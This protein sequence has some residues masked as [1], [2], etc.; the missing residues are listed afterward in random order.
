MT[1]GL[2]LFLGCV[3]ISLTGVWAMLYQ[4]KKKFPVEPISRQ[5]DTNILLKMHDLEREIE[6]LETV[7]MQITNAMQANTQEI[8]NRIDFINR[9]GGKR[10]KELFDGLRKKKKTIQEIDF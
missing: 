5:H 8:I 7:L 6:D 4:P 10:A 1:D 3:V 9:E 2:Y